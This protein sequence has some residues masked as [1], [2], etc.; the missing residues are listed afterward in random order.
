MDLSRREFMQAGTVSL[1]SLQG[2]VVPERGDLQGTEAS[3]F[4]AVAHLIGDSDARPA[5]NSEFFNQENANKVYY[6]YLYD[7]LDTG[8]QWWITQ[9]SDRW[10]QFRM[11]PK[12]QLN[13]VRSID[14]SSFFDHTFARPEAPDDKNWEYT[15]AE[16]TKVNSEIELASSTTL[17]STQ[18]GNYPPGTEAIPGIA[19]RV[20][21][22]PTAG[23]ADAG[24]FTADNGFGIGEDSTDSYVFLRKG[25]SE[26]KVYRSDWN[27]F[28]PNSRLWTNPQ[29]VVTRFPHLFYGGGSIRFR[30]LIHSDNETKLETLHTI[31]PENT[32][33]GWTDGPPFNQPN[34]PIQF[35]SSSLSGGSLR[36]NAAHYEFSESNSETRINGEHIEAISV[37]TT[38]WTPLLSWRKRSGWDMVNVKPQK[39]SI[40]A[41]NN[42][43]KLSLQLNTTLDSPTWTLPTSTDSDETAVEVATGGTFTDTG[44]R[45]WP[46]YAV[47]GTG[48]NSGQ[49]SSDDLNFNLPAGQTVTLA[50]QAVGSTGN[51][52]GAVGWEEYF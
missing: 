38:G 3:G 41:R 48:N 11:I 16:V 24:Y 6:G 30:A 29:P 45:R 39:I 21:G 17:M 2:G 10:I 31:T 40:V 22:T 27:G 34:L 43:L 15:A 52:Y 18:R 33:G 51:A 19:C 28:V 37:S 13:E 23:R 50:A 26:Y 47:A 1:L 42:D 49:P 9:D 35:S 14:Y 20:T 36:A 32:P 4:Q 12:T 8:D 7:E 5:P 25:G 44:Q 46:G